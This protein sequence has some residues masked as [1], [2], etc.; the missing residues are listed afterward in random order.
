VPHRRLTQL[1]DDVALG[2]V[3]LDDAVTKLADAGREDE[4]A[5]LLAGRA[6]LPEAEVHSMLVRAPEQ[7][8][9][10]VCRR[11][12]LS[13][14][15]YSAVLRLR[16]RRRRGGPASPATL[17]SAYR[18]LSELPAAEVAAYLASYQATAPSESDS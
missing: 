6:T 12:G 13:V 4:L 3:A 10:I 7:A 5:A 18:R 1:Q 11:A 2:L 15:G 16:H 9:A 14:N 17:L 8:V